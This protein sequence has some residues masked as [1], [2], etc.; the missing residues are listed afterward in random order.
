MLTVDESVEIGLD[1]FDSIHYDLIRRDQLRGP[2]PDLS[3]FIVIV[4]EVLKTKY[5]YIE[6]D[7][8]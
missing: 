5:K 6:L 8:D 4:V 1:V 3:K 2:F 7:K